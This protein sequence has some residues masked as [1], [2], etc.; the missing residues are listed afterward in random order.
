MK[1]LIFI[2]LLFVMPGVTKAGGPGGTPFNT[3]LLFMY[4]GFIFLMVA[5]LGSN[6]LIKYVKRK[7]K[8]REEKRFMMDHAESFKEL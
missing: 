2:F 5:I 3:D 7:I 4:G 8:E 6:W 1:N